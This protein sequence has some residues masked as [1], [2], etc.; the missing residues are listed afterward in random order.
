MRIYTRRGDDGETGLLGSERVKKSDPRIEVCGALDE[1]SAA[2]GLAR[3]L[4]LAEPVDATVAR[5]QE[6]LLSAGAEVAGSEPMNARIAAE[7]VTRLERTIDA[8]EAEL[9]PLAGFLVPGG[10]PGPAALHLARTLCRRVERSLVGAGGQGREGSV[11]VAYL[12]RLSD[13]LFVLARRAN[14][15][16]GAAEATWGPSRPSTRG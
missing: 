14:A 1:T 6:D 7:D 15:L 2:L 5:I 12:N 16:A 3:A 11:L 4:G 13:L 9:R 8:H 10:A